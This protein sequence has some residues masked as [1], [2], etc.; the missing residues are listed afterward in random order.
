MSPFVRLSNP[1]IKPGSVGRSRSASASSAVTWNS[2]AG[3]RRTLNH[4]SEQLLRVAANVGKLDLVLA[5]AVD[6]VAKGAMG[7]EPDAMAKGDEGE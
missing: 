1:G 4:P 6:E 5:G 3:R 7:R 2:E